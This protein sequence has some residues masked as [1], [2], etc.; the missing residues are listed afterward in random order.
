MDA[1]DVSYD[2]PDRII[3]L[4]PIFQAVEKAVTSLQPYDT[5]WHGLTAPTP[6]ASRRNTDCTLANIA[7]FRRAFNPLF[8]KDVAIYLGATRRP[9]V[10][11]EYRDDNNTP[12]MIWLS[13]AIF[14]DTGSGQECVVNRNIARHF[15]SILR[16]K[17]EGLY[18]A[19]YYGVAVQF[20]LE[21]LE[22]I[23]GSCMDSKQRMK[24]IE[25]YR[26]NALERFVR[27]QAV[28]EDPKAAIDD[29]ADSASQFLEIC[30]SLANKMLKFADES[31]TPYLYAWRESA[32]KHL[33][34]ILRG[35]WSKGPRDPLKAAMK[36]YRAGKAML[37][38]L[39]ITPTGKAILMDMRNHEI[40]GC[41]EIDPGKKPDVRTLECTVGLD[42]LLSHRHDFAV[43]IPLSP[44]D[45]VSVPVKAS[46][47]KL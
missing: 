35:S 41:H 4:D 30:M 39:L 14:S 6:E 16:G 31:E 10:I 3:R 8:G 37:K 2:V 21:C 42:P 7:D 40:V 26:R 11:L 23:Q 34:E 12:Q 5:D 19:N 18:Y 43:K 45:H 28:I 27:L 29:R 46:E 22:G 13:A 1:S 36:Q 32:Q 17:D 24:N 25:N 44:T 9:R 33:H 47:K 15:V 38:E 20:Y